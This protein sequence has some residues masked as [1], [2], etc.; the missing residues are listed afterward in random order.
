M[1]KRSV[2]FS[3]VHVLFCSVPFRKS[4]VPLS[5]VLNSVLVCSVPLIK[6]L[7][8]LSAVLNSV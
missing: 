1:I 7:V 3:D 4:L 8:S 5:A 6:S 2:V